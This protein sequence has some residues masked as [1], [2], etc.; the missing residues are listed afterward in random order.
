MGDGEGRRRIVSLG[1]P[2]CEM[3]KICPIG[4]NFHVTRQKNGNVIPEIWSSQQT[5]AK[6]SFM[7]K[8]IKNVTVGFVAWGL[9]QGGS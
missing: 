3:S 2:E 8:K 5:D 7:G 4:L 9:K 6:L 1:Q